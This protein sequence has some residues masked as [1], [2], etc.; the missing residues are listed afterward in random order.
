MANTEVLGKKAFVSQPVERVFN[1]FSDLSNFVKNLP[2]EHREKVEATTDT[3]VVKANGMEL[4]IQAVERVPYSMHRFEQ[5]GTPLFPFTIWIHIGEEEGGAST[6]QLELHAEL[7]IM[8]KMMLGSKL[9]DGID[10]L[11]DQLA[12]GLSGQVPPQ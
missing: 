5:Y 2:E 7:N 1:A 6:M 9:K 12:A 4:G 8:L 3:L 11:T 10:K